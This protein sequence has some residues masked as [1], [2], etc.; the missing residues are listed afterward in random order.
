MDTD[1]EYSARITDPVFA[2][3]SLKRSFSMT[4]NES[5][6]LVFAKT[7]YKFGHSTTMVQ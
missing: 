4:E 1:L 6:G 2:K 7:V 3:T 5:F